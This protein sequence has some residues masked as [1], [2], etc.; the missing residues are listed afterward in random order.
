M[1]MELLIWAGLFVIGEAMNAPEVAKLLR[2]DG[3]YE[4]EELPERL[5]WPWN[6]HPG[7]NTFAEVVAGKLHVVDRGT[8]KTQLRFY[9]RRWYAHPKLG[10]VA[11]VRLRVVSCSGPAGV[12]LLMA[13]GVHEAGLTF[14]PDRV[15][16]HRLGLSYRLDTT[17]DFHIYRLEVKAQ[18]LRL[19]VDG[20]I[21]LDA[22]GKF[23]PP[24]HQ[25]RNL[26]GFGSCSS[27]ATGEAYW[28]Y[29]RYL[30]YKPPVV[31]GA[32][33][34]IIYKRP[35]IYA[36]FPSLVKGREGTLYLAFS[37][38]VRRS[39]IDPTGGGARRM[40]KDGGRTWIEVEGEW[41]VRPAR[42]R[43]DGGQAYAR[44]YGWR[45]VPKEQE[46]EFRARGF[47]TREVR[48]GVVA[49]LSGAYAARKL[50]RSGTWERWEIEVP[51][52]A[53][54]MN[55]NQA[56][57]LKTREGIHLVAVYG[58]EKPD[59]SLSPLAG[60]RS[61]SWVLRSDDEGDSWQLLPLAPPTRLERLSPLQP[62][63]EASRLPDLWVPEEGLLGFTETALAEAPDGTILA[64]MRPEPDR[65]GY[66]Y[67]AVSH[68]GGLTWSPPARTPIWGYPAHL[69]V[70]PDG[71]VLCTYGYRRP[72]MGIRACLSRDG[73]KTWDIAHEFVLRADGQRS[74]SD[75]G[76]PIT[77]QAEDGTLVTV[78]YHTTG[79]GVTHIAATRWRIPEG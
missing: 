69:L 28:D 30:L 35:G 38:R 51:P 53:S 1:R 78:Y 6:L 66:L 46:E 24:A 36:C 19:W 74:G 76:Y 11:E 27:P 22:P 62:E 16:F 12:V 60:G 13:D 64:L 75:L 4:G 55:Y 20:Q 17:D 29:V 44:A 7:E 9:S 2:W 72:P 65:H 21:A 23:T 39:H 32:E 68:D 41:P 33:H 40:S 48:P 50:P 70:L 34:I 14:Y 73:G 56:A 31:E 26:I 63:A 54:L 59:T 18:D 77:Q 57:E 5:E 49:Y 37:T 15:E 52:Q 45:E 47:V 42:R 71:S 3:G 61:T 43:R 25:G 10:A 67:Q 8:E 58:R 79:D